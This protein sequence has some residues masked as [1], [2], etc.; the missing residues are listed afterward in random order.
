MFLKYPSRHSLRQVFSYKTSGVLQLKQ[1]LEVGPSH[2]PHLFEH[3][4]HIPK[5]LLNVPAGHEPIQ[6]PLSRYFPDT[7]DKQLISLGPWHVSQVAEQDW[8][9]LL[10]VL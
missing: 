6:A 2:S 8:Q 1:S 4:S 9:L 5:F 3:L 7:Q 10:N